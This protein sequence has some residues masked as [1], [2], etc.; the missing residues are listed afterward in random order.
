MITALDTNVIVALWHDEEM[1]LVAL[2][3]LEEARNQG[4]LVIS[5]PVF[6]ELA[7]HPG[8][9]V[10]F[11]NQFLE[12]TAIDVDWEISEDVWRLAGAAFRTYAIRRKKE[13]RETPRRILA[14]FVIGAH[15]MQRRSRLITLDGGLFRSVFPDL[16]LLLL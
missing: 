13:R 6:A 7:A 10:E 15:A 3:A 1:S 12:V 8:R 16:D 2:K 4:A 11:V 9:T 14:D 5:A